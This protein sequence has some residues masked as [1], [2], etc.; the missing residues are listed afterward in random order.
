MLILGPGAP[1]AFFPALSDP[2]SLAKSS[3]TRELISRN[4]DFDMCPK[5]S[6]CTCGSDFLVF[7]VLGT[8]LIFSPSKRAFDIAGLPF[9]IKETLV[10]S[11]G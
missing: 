9:E 3:L 2:L 5:G 10:K 4:L 8:F 7:W 6:N 1:A 11:E